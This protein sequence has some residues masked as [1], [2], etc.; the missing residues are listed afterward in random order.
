MVMKVMA[1]T[2]LIAGVLMFTASCATLAPRD[3]KLVD[4]L[5]AENRVCSQNLNL[6]M[7]ENDVLKTEIIKL[8]QHNADLKSRNNLFKSDLTALQA[9]YKNDSAV[10]NERYSSLQQ[11]YDVFVKQSD[12]KVQELT[13]LNKALEKRMA[14]EI[15]RL[16]EAIRRQE[17][18]FIKEKEALV[19]QNTK[20]ELEYQAAIDAMQ[21]QLTV[22]SSENEVLKSRFLEA[23]SQ[24][25]AVK[26][27]LE[28]L[29]KERKKLIDART[30]DSD[31]QKDDK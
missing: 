28:A 6:F 15:A 8:K 4:Q 24:L 10:W 26:K 31:A 23:E 5:K 1:V 11:K 16:A 12:D 14:D 22:L 30:A 25:E 2:N 19:S 21:K 7:R 20:K 27:D 13:H 17:V 9:K 3:D 18:D 29:Q